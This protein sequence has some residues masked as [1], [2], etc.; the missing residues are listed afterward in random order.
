MK[1]IIC[2]LSLILLPTIANADTL[3]LKTNNRSINGTVRYVDST[4]YLEA[5]YLTGSKYYEV[6]RSKVVKDEI[7]DTTYNQ[8][9]PDPNITAYEFHPAMWASITAPSSRKTT[10][11]SKTNVGAKTGATNGPMST[12]ARTASGIGAAAAEERPP[13]PP[14]GSDKVT[15]ADRS[16]K[17]GKLVQ[18][19]PDAVQLREN[20]KPS[21]TSID[22]S[23]VLL[24]TIGH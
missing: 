20:G 12:A 18:M 11:T 22:R 9:A 23:E 15:L 7:N 6:P 8:G 13:A 16:V 17:V 5:E 10:T 19:T 21:D 24:V 14:A 2:L 1:S 4:F 3:T